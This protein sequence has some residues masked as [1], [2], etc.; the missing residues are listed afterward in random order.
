MSPS[1][2]ALTT[3]YADKKDA[4]SYI[5]RFRVGDFVCGSVGIKMAIGDTAMGGKCSFDGKKL[6]VFVGDFHKSVKFDNH[7]RTPQTMK[8]CHKCGGYYDVGIEECPH[9]G[10]KT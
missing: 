9:C 3:V 7:S 4:A 1:C 6:E 2:D 5:A 10:N 8:S